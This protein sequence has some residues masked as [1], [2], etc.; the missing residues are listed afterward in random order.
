MSLSTPL[1]P[2]E[3]FDIADPPEVKSILGVTLV[4]TDVEIVT[5]LDVGFVAPP[6][7]S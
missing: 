1:I 6:S 7:T 2:I 5:P 3:G 4:P